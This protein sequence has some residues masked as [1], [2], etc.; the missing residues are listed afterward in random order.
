MQEAMEEPYCHEIKC[1]GWVKEGEVGPSS[2]FND[3]NY[4]EARNSL[5]KAIRKKIRNGWDE[6][7]LETTR[8]EQNRGRDL[9]NG[10]KKLETTRNE[11]NRGRDL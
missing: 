5:E 10:L 1:A 4:R 2:L 3:E 7:K 8:N 11:Q 6:K 9:L